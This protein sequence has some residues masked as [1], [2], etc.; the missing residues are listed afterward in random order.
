MHVRLSALSGSAVFFSSIHQAGLTVLS[1][2]SKKKKRL[3]RFP[4][5]KEG[6]I[7]NEVETV[8]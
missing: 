2:R 5:D 1:L 8:Y 7:A 4:T 6:N 3:G